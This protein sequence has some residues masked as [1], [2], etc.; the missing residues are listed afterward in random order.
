MVENI[1]I[2]GDA[3]APCTERGNETSATASTTRRSTDGSHQIA[4]L[5][6][7]NLEPVAL[8]DRQRDAVQ[9]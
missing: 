7:L 1:Q 8:T 2:K 3:V 9:Q 5:A 4:L 6:E